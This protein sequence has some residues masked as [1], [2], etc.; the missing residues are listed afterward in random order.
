MIREPLKNIIIDKKKYLNF[1][2]NKLIFMGFWITSCGGGQETKNSN[3]APE[4]ITFVSPQAVY[5][6]ENSG[7]ELNRPY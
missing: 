7:Q 2:S 6:L 5:G 1:K 3:L 4:G